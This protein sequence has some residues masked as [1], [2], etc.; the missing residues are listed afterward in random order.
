MLFLHH[1]NFQA[2]WWP[3]DI[4]HQLNI[5]CL[6]SLSRR[7]QKV[8]NQSCSN[9]VYW[10]Q[11]YVCSIKVT[12][13]RDRITVVIYLCWNIS[14]LPAKFLWVTP[15]LAAFPVS[16]GTYFFLLKCIFPSGMLS[17][18]HWIKTKSPFMFHG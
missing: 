14:D 17:H 7:T 12:T 5:K 4:S 10:K 18:Y 8:L 1:L 16:W 11:F 15:W 3:A 13:A 2:K 6:A 9:L